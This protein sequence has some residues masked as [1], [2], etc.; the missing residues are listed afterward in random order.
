M[1]LSAFLAIVGAETSFDE[2]NGFPCN[3]NNLIYYNYYRLRHVRI[4]H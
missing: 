1:E 2:N 3:L 4:L